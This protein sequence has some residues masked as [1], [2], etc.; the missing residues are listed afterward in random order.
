[1]AVSCCCRH[2]HS[3]PLIYGVDIPVILRSIQRYKHIAMIISSSSTPNLMEGSS[4]VGQ[5]RR[6]SIN[7]IPAPTSLLMLYEVEISRAS[8]RLVVSIR[9]H[10]DCSLARWEEV[11]RYCSYHCIFFIAYRDVISLV[12]LSSRLQEV[13]LLE[14]VFRESRVLLSAR[15]TGTI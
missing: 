11:I 5:A 4:L 1:M 14:E 15:P 12:T 10:F 8:N 3:Q 2:S 9:S 13:V 7:C 6:Y